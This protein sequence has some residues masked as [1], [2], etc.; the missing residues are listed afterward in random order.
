MK[1]NTRYIVTKDSECGAFQ[2]GDHIKL[3]SNGDLI[4]LEAGGWIDKE[5]VK[6]ATVGM[7]YALDTEYLERKKRLL[8]AQLAALDC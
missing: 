6:E 8:Q 4:C 7:E 5:F 3:D 2:V 1:V